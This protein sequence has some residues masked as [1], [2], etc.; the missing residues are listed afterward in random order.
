MGH[1]AKQ[2]L[3]MREQPMFFA[4]AGSQVLD[5]LNSLLQ[6]IF[7]SL[8]VLLDSLKGMDEISFPVKRQFS[9]AMLSLYIIELSCTFIPA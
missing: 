9:L 2:T 7:I 3:R 6:V 5:V 4:F 1:P 8:A